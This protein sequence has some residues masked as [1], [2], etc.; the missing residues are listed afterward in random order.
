MFRESEM[1]GIFLQGKSKT[2]KT[3]T[4]K[5]VI[6][7][8]LDENICL[9]KSKNFEN[10][11]S[12]E[13]DRDIWVVVKYQNNNIFIYTMGDAPEEW[14]EKF[15]AVIKKVESIDICIGAMHDTPYAN[16]RIGECISKILKIPKNVHKDKNDKAECNKLNQLDA[17]LI[18]KELGI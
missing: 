10:A 9:K 13:V 17:H 4:L 11:L 7:V 5:K 15:D 6:K 18:L 3:K 2:G 8:L 14:K 12:E 1:K 16:Q